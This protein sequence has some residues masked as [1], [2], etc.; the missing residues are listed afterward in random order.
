MLKHDR[1]CAQISWACAQSLAK[2]RFFRKHVTS[3]PLNGIALA[4][5]ASVDRSSPGNFPSLFNSAD[6]VSQAAQMPRSDKK[7]IQKQTKRAHPFEPLHHQS[8][9]PHRDQRAPS[10]VIGLSRIAKYRQHTNLHQYHESTTG[11]EQHLKDN[12]MGDQVEI[13]KHGH[14]HGHPQKQHQQQHQQQLQQQPQQDQPPSR[15]YQSAAGTH[16]LTPISKTD[17]R[18]WHKD[19]VAIRNTVAALGNDPLETQA[20]GCTAQCRVQFAC[21][22]ASAPQ[23]HDLTEYYHQAKEDDSERDGRKKEDDKVN[24]NSSSSEKE[25]SIKTKTY[26]GN[27]AVGASGSVDGRGWAKWMVAG[28][29]SAV[30]FTMQFYVLD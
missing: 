26:Q 20:S 18:Q 16:M 8:H 7:D 3:K 4:N 13:G 24:E 19:E 11:Q 28:C 21:G 12:E 17:R 2:V 30:V 6:D 25:R 29:A 5:P 9:Y 22:T 23:Y 15:L 27:A 14:V 10:E 1:H